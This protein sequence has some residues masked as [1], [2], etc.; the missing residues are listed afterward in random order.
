ME[1]T[2][3]LGGNS[4]PLV[5]KYRID[6]GITIIGGVP[7]VSDDATGDSEGVVACTTIAALNT[8]GLSVDTA[9]STDALSGT[10]ADN[11]GF[12][13]LIINPDAVYEAKF[14]EGATEDTALTVLTSAAAVAGGTTVTGATDEF[15]VWG[16]T[17]A[18][19]GQE[20]RCT[21]AAT[22]VHA[23][24][25]PIAADDT[26]L[27][28]GAVRGGVSHYPQFSTLLTQYD[29][30]SAADVDNDNFVVVD[31]R[32]RDASAD[33]RNNSFAELVAAKHVFSGSASAA[34]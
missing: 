25:Q 2:Y 16:L 26:W 11:A 4:T 17:G 22:V 15:T 9:T 20:R 28:A 3:N 33:G 6:G 12:I 32:L 34:T 30:N 27:E 5:R 13:S 1:W 7:V 18:N 29:A 19:A 31:M 14:T 10:S 23:F 24:P 21:G 8:V